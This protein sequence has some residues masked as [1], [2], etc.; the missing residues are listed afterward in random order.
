MNAPGL[1]RVHIRKAKTTWLQA[2]CIDRIAVFGLLEFDPQPRVQARRRRLGRRPVL[3][4]VVAAAA[5]IRTPAA[6]VHAGVKAAKGSCCYRL[7]RNRGRSRDSSLLI[8]LPAGGSFVFC[9]TRSGMRQRWFSSF[10]IASFWIFV[11]LLEKEKI[12]FNS[13]GAN[14]LNH[15]DPILLSFKEVPFKHHSRNVGCR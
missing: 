1:N 11:R 14:V 5:A 8:D 6:V 2:I 3:W 7:G 12:T 4:R 15:R 10:Q 13:C 9:V